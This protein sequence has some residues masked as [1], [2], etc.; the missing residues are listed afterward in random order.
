MLI[1]AVPVPKCFPIKN[2]ISGGP[3]RGARL[4]KD[5]NED[6]TAD[7]K[8]MIPAPPSRSVCVISES[9]DPRESLEVTY[10]DEV[11]LMSVLQRIG[12]NS[13]IKARVKKHR[14]RS[15]A[16]GCTLT[17]MAGVVGRN[18]GTCF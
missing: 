14:W 3:I 7:T 18:F 12:Y 10:C 17:V 5:G 9:P 16:S 11:T 1:T 6:A 4:A 15:N 13:W 8:R 2:T